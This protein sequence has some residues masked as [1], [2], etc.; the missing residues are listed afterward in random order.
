MI[1][2]VQT[3]STMLMPLGVIL[4]L[5]MAAAWLARRLRHGRFRGAVMRPGIEILASRQ[6]GLQSSLLIVEAEGQRFLLGAGRNGIQRIGRLGMSR[7]GA[8][9]SF[10]PTGKMDP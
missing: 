1:F 8:E 10:P 9:E 4:G 6:M 7:G 3:I 5:L 2:G